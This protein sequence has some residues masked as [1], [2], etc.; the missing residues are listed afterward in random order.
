MIVLQ[1]QCLML[2]VTQEGATYSVTINAEG[3]V[4]EEVDK[5]CKLHTHFPSFCRGTPS[6]AVAEERIGNGNNVLVELS[7]KMRINC[8]N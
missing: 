2:C 1:L 8:A 4:I 6:T 7:E 5:F 3:G